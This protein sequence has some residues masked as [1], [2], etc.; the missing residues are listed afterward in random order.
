MLMII[1]LFILTLIKAA[2]M[3]A[4]SISIFCLML[5]LL[6]RFNV[7]RKFLIIGGMVFFM[8]IV[9]FNL[10]FILSL[11]SNFSGDTYQKKAKEIFELQQASGVTEFITNF[12]YGVYQRS[13]DSF[14]SNPFFGSGDYNYIGQHS[15]W[16]D[17]LGFIGIFG[18]LFYFFTLLTIY[19]RSM[20]L[21][22]KDDR[23]I[24]RYI[25]S[26]FFIIM[27]LNPFESPDFLLIVFVLIPCII[28]YLKTTSVPKQKYHPL[29]NYF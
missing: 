11:L 5:G 15:Y 24:Y 1:V 13:I 8:V 2:F 20:L 29:K 25:M 22:N 17:R 4:L 23:Q 18:T 28:N 9:L 27:V 21:I 19:K 10:Q 26:I 6:L 7:K 12:R 16:I 3:T 14:L